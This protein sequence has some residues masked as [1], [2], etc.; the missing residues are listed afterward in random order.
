MIRTVDKQEA[1]DCPLVAITSFRSH[2]EGY[3][4][5]ALEDMNIDI[6]HL[7]FGRTGFRSKAC[8]T[9]INGHYVDGTFY[10]KYTGTLLFFHAYDCDFVM[11]NYPNRKKFRT[12]LLDHRVQPHGD[13]V[14][15][16]YHADTIICNGSDALI[17]DIH[18][19]APF[20]KEVNNVGFFTTHYASPTR[21]PKTAFVQAVG[22][23]QCPLDLPKVCQMLLDE[24]YEVNFFDHVLHRSIHTFAGVLFNDTPPHVHYVTSEKPLPEGVRIVKPGLDYIRT[25]TSCSHYVGYG[26][27]SLLTNSFV[28]GAT[29]ILLKSDWL[30]KCPSRFRSVIETLSYPAAT[31]SALRLCLTAPPKDDSQIREYLFG[32]NRTDVLQKVEEAVIQSLEKQSTFSGVTW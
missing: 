23:Y 3:I 29:Q 30:P 28:P 31:L 27:S 7:D 8:S 4:R 2:F 14:R 25:L 17:Q 5:F 1:L 10:T 11:K 16:P 9:D 13:R 15:S 18:G 26:S 20:G 24:G 6:A 12:L 22:N 32:E 19:T 21:K